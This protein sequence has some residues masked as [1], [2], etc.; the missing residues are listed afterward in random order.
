MRNAMKVARWEI[1]RNLKN[2]TFV[3]SIFLTP[4]IFLFFMFVGSLVGGSDDE[5]VHVYVNDRIGVLEGMKQTAK[6]QQLDWTL[7]KTDID[8]AK[9]KTKVKDQE[10]TAYVFID[11]KTVESG[12][13]PV[14]LSEDLEDSASFNLQVLEGPLKAWQMQKAGLSDQQL[15][16]VAKPVQF[17]DMAATKDEEKAEKEN[18]M[19]KLVPGA[20]GGIVFLSIAFSGMYIFQSASSEKK[21]KIAEIILSSVTPGELMQGKI[22]GYFILGMIQ[23]VVYAVV[24]TAVTMWKLDGDILSYLFVPETLLYLLIAVLGYLLFAAIYVGAGATIAD[25]TS[26]SNFQGV[27]MMLPFLAF[28]FIG[29]V[30]SNPEGTVAQ[31]GSYIPFSAPGVLIMRLAML[32]EW[33]WLQIII[34][35]A[36]LVFSIWLFMKIA[37]KIFKMGIMMYG[38]NATPK[39]IWKWLRA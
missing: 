24:A 6:A 7:K 32:D 39:E 37:G 22:I 21:D 9:A 16:S 34:S 25:M 8:E 30:I 12:T 23:A 20:F 26:S 18:F 29:P 3:I 19:A 31:I 1:K 17:E 35:L 27:V 2:K 14:Y 11:E 38:K 4:A 10:Q 28:A 13:I 15:A 5:T 36:V 33:P